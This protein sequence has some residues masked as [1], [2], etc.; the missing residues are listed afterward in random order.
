MPATPTS[1]DC[2]RI[3]RQCMSDALEG[4]L[5][6]MIITQLLHTR[7][8]GLSEL[9]C[10]F[11]SSPYV[12]HRPDDYLGCDTT[13][14]KIWILIVNIQFFHL[15]VIYDE[16]DEGVLARRSSISLTRSFLESCPWTVGVLRNIAVCRLPC[17]CLK[18]EKN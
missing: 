6:C 5:C 10:T 7:C 14:L 12:S 11:Q 3:K 13:P 2:V 15:V 8:E 18:Q 17:T 16:L 4:Q 9:L 1:Q